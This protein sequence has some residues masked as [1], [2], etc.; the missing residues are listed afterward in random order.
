MNENIKDNVWTQVLRNNAAGNKQPRFEQITNL[1]IGKAHGD[2]EDVHA[3]GQGADEGA[4]RP[5]GGGD[6]RQSRAKLRH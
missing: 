5:G 1:T 6:R 2:N 4:D 3:D